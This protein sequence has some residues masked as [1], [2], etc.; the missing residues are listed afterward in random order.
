MDNFKRTIQKKDCY[1]L[2]TAAWCT[3]CQPVKKIAS[4]LKTT[5]VILIDVNDDDEIASYHSITKLP[6]LIL[7]KNGVL[8]EI[9]VGS[10]KCEIALAIEDNVEDYEAS[11]VCDDF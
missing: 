11:L 3:Q 8:K 9:Y 10:K 2:F 1:V 4:D 5:N 7:Y 6:T